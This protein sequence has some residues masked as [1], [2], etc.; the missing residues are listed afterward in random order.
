MIK[1]T[2]SSYFTP[3]DDFEENCERTLAKLRIYPGDTTAAEVTKL[4]GVP[5]T[6]SVTKGERIATNVPGQFR[7]G[8]INGWFLS[9]EAFVKSKD[10]RRHLDWLL[11]KVEGSVDALKELQRRPDV[12]M[13]V[14]CIW[15]SKHGGGGPSLWP[16]QMHRLAA[17]NL[18]CS[19][20]F[21]YYGEG[22]G[23]EEGLQAEAGT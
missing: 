17:L 16:Q 13:C 21:Q 3:L 9:S 6:S 22:Q 19:F 2:T 8:N 11:T 14:C 20:D 5:P 12:R 10:L 18:E 1:D 4:L 15:W 23:G 7:T